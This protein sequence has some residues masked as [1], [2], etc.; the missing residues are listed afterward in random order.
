LRRE[1]SS[2]ASALAGP[3]A[4]LNPVEFPLDKFVEIYRPDPNG[5]D[6]LTT[7]KSSHNE[8]R[9]SYVHQ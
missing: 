4:R 7:F 8:P 1:P 2:A 3:F 9:I 6:Y 5:L